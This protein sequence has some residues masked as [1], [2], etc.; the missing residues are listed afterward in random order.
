MNKPIENIDSNN[1]IRILRGT[2]FAVIFSLVLLICVALI[3]ANTSL[4]EGVMIP[5][6][7]VISAIS[8]LIGSLISSRKIRKNGIV[9]GGMVGLM[10]IL[11]LYILSSLIKQNFEISINSIIMIIVCIIAGCI[12]GIIGVNIRK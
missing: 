12:G 7:I 8:I 1:A 11:S 2:V 6:I 9:N 10:Y 3:L 5:A 4:P